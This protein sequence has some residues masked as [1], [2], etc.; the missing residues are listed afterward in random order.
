MTRCDVVKSSALGPRDGGERE[1]EENRGTGHQMPYKSQCSPGGMPPLWRGRLSS[2]WTEN[3]KERATDLPALMLY[4]RPSE[5]QLSLQANKG[6]LKP[7]P[8]FA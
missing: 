4:C 7:L 3:R 8:D 6:K 2:N 5:Q 1:R